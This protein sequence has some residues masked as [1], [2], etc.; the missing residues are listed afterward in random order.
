MLEINSCDSLDWIVMA[1]GQVLTAD[2]LKRSL[3]DTI[4]KQLVQF[5][6]CGKATK[7][8]FKIKG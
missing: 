5:D 7:F 2:H 4:D 3:K 8:K 1:M 6:P